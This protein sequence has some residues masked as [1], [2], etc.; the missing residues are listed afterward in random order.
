MR[1]GPGRIHCFSEVLDSIEYV[2]TSATKV[3]TKIPTEINLRPGQ[4]LDV[5]LRSVSVNA[6]GNDVAISLPSITVF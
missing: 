1:G 5:R 2:A 6:V 3:P 4:S